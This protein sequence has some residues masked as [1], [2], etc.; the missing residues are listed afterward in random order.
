MNTWLQSFQVYLR[1][2]MLAMLALGFSAGLPL[3][4]VFGTL[5]FWLRKEGI[6]RSTIGYISWVA[7]LY[8]V[9]FL[10]SPLV[11]RL[12]IPLITKSI[13]KRRGWMLVAQLGVLCG[14]VLLGT[15]DPQTDLTLLV[16][17]A[18]FVAFSSATQDISLDAWRIES[19]PVKEQGAMAGTYQLGYRLGMLLA[20]GG[21]FS[22]AHFY[23]WSTAYIVMGLC[24]LIGIITTLLVSEPSNSHMEHPQQEQAVIEFIARNSALPTW[25]RDAIAWFIGA[26]VCP[27]TEF[28]IRNGV[29]SILILIFIGTFRLSDI[30]MGVMAGPFYADM[31]YT[32]IQVGMVSKTFGVFVTIAGALLGGVLVMRWGILRVLIIA[33]V[34]VVTTNLIFVWLATQDPKT[35]LLAIVITADN[36][37]GGIA[38]T[39]F[40]AYLSS[41]T[42]TSYTA[43]QYALLSSVMLLPA[44][45]IG[46]FSGEVVD[47]F[48]YIN[49]FI[50]AACLGIPAILLAIYLGT[51]NDVTNLTFSTTLSSDEKK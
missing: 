20:G 41:L 22:I 39:V 23:N 11:D 8:G 49:F 6:D 31:G 14:L 26:V 30:T 33:G 12:P 42:N 51:R 44:K 15:V 38:G 46:G 5:S 16:I 25:L 40:I 34:L 47:H 48:G 4:L 24:M 21:A 45:F 32:E 37:S 3:L 13:G 2:K 7:L 29:I 9:K 17:F 28:F 35:I 18:I 27:F 43:T 50:Y 36:L 19:A 1:P 10:W